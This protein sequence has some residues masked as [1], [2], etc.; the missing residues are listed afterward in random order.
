MQVKTTVKYNSTSAEIMLKRMTTLSAGE[1]GKTGKFIYYFGNIN[2][3]K[4][5]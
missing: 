3:L 2:Y 4:E 5:N 1:C